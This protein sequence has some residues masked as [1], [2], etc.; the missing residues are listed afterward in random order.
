MASD[1][2]TPRTPVQPRAIRRREQV[3]DAAAR[4]LDRQ[5]YDGLTTNAVAAEAGVAVGTVYEYFRGREALVHG[6]L[7]RHGARL[8]AAVDVALATGGGRAAIADRTVDLLERFWREEPGYRAAWTATQLPGLLRET[9]QAWSVA[10]TERI[11]IALGTMTEQP[12]RWRRRVARTVVHL[13]SGLVMVAAFSTEPE[14]RAMLVETKI[15]VEAYLAA[16]LETRATEVSGVR[17]RR[18]STRKKG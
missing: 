7:L 5:G 1:A 15:A 2:R 8:E 13:V 18:G 12:L 10:F 14:R 11:A 4:I 6:L 3:L 16:R 9:G 17:S